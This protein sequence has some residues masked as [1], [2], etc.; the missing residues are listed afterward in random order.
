MKKQ[1]LSSIALIGLSFNAFAYETVKPVSPLKDFQI[2]NVDSYTAQRAWNTIEKSPKTRS[3]CSNR[4]MVWSYDMK[5]YYGI[6]SEKILIHYTDLLNLVGDNDGKFK[7]C[8]FGIGCGGWEYHIAPVVKVEGQKMVFDKQFMD[9]I[10]SP[11]QWETRFTKQ[12]N[13]KLN[14]Y[15][16]RKKIV[17]NLRK[18]IKKYHDS[19]RNRHKADLSRHA[20]RM[21]EQARQNDGS[22]KVSCKPIT[23]IA[24][25]DLDQYNSWCHIQ[26]TSMYYWNQNDLRRL[27]NNFDYLITNQNYTRENIISGGQN[28]QATRF[29]KE[30]LEIS[31]KQAFP[32]RDY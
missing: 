9:S 18:N 7:R 17:E 20:L 28:H 10:V 25:H 24:E 5:R 8:L 13:D 27:N 12:T 21:I 4:A 31:I 6:D 22:Y 3:I 19:D 11:A 15:K 26:Y 29:S 23:H 2:S 32:S 14:N 1:L 16:Q 30:I